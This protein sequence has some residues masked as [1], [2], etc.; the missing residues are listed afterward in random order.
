MSIAG[1]RR[2]ERRNRPPQGEPF[3]WFT[4]EMLESNAWAAL[5]LAAGRVIERIIIEHMAHADNENGALI[6]TYADF[7]KFGIRRMSIK[8]AIDEAVAL[9]FMIVTQKGRASIGIDR[10]PTHFALS[11]L[12]LKDGTPASKR[13]KAITGKE[14]DFATAFMLRP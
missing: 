9:G 3:I 7:E 11:W 12:D 8:R 2:R 10:W 13:W 1:R 5:S 4:R 14:Q 6:V